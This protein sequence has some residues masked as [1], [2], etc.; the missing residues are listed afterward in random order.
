M[1]QIPP[2]RLHH[3]PAH[4]G[5][6]VPPRVFVAVDPR[7]VLAIVT[8][9]LIATTGL[10]LWPLVA[11]LVLAAWTAHLAT[12]LFRRFDRA[13]HGR[14]AAAATITAVLVVLILAPLVISIAALIPAALGLLEQLKSARGGRGALSALVSDGVG[15]PTTGQ[16]IV[17]LVKEYGASASKA[18]LAVAGVSVDVIIGAFVFFTALFTLLVAGGRAYAWLERN[19]PLEPEVLGR[20]TAAFHQAGRGLLLGMGLTALV[21]GAFATAIYIALGIPRA[22]LLGLLSTVASL[23]PVTGSAIVWVPV[24]AG[25]AISGQPGKALPLS[26]LC[27]GLV[28]TVDNV[29]RPWLSGRADVGIPATVILIGIFGGLV[30]FGPWGLLL[31]PLVLRLTTEALA[32]SRERR[33]FRRAG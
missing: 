9:V 8:V 1:L 17:S 7:I 18:F 21:Q 4:L 6:V 30:V 12:P 26:A 14:R 28:G 2:R 27:I 16:G 19:A 10:T 11:P 15:R 3:Q 22:I 33:V 29:V 23:I 24:A 5:S 20:F 32:V 31:G 13:F 25:L